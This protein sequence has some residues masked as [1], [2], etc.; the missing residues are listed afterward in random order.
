MLYWVFATAVT[1]P[2]LAIFNKPEVLSWL[3]LLLLAL[4]G[5]WAMGFP[6]PVRELSVLAFLLL[7]GAVYYT[8]QHFLRGGEA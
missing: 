3:V 8:L 5:T 2:L 6:F 7:E 1:L 4:W